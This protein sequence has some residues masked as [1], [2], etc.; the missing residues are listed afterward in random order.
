MTFE[1]LLK[2]TNL[3]STAKDQLSMVLSVKTKQ[4]LLNRSDAEQIIAAAIDEIDHGSVEPV[5][6]LVVRK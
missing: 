1:E 6:T 2:T 5:E 4:K 3:P